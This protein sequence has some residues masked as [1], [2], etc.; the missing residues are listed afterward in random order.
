MTISEQL[1]VRFFEDR[2]M[3]INLKNGN[4]TVLDEIGSLFWRAISNNETDDIFKVITSEYDVDIDTVKSDFNDFV[5]K[6]MELEIL[7]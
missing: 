1:V 4:V 7:W 5:A 2:A 6:L 3:I